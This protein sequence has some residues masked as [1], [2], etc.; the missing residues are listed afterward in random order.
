[1]KFY[2]TSRPTTDEVTMCTV[3]EYNDQAGFRVRLDEYD[4]EGFLML[5][6]LHNKKIRGP[7]SSFLKINTQLPLVVIDSGSVDG[8]VYLS[9]KAVKSLH[10]KACKE[11]F[12][13]NNR[14]FNLALR[15]QTQNPGLGLVHTFQEINSPHLEEDEHPWTLLQNREWDQLK[16][17]SETQIQVIKLQ[18]AKL[19]GIKPQSIRT[20]FSAYSFAIR[21]NELVRDRLIEIRD[22]W[23]RPGSGSGQGW[24]NNELYEDTSRCNLEIQPIGIPTFQIKVTAYHRDRCYEVINEVRAKLTANDNGLEHVQFQDSEHKAI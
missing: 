12:I 10:S 22:M 3:I 17:L 14:L 2:E 21:G 20:K 15:L 19:F 16:A 7:I 13:L 11:R 6:E 18:H 9:K 4:L 1:M 24:S 5:V 23:N 8:Q